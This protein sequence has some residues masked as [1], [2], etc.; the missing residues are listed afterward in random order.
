MA[1]ACPYNCKQGRLFNTVTR[2]FQSCPHCNDI[3]NDLSS[4]QPLSQ[5]SEDALARL[6]IPSELIGVK[7]DPDSFFDA[8]AREVFANVTFRTVLDELV[9]IEMAINSGRVLRGSRY[10]FTGLYAD[11]T[12]YVQHC[13]QEALRHGLSV[14]PYVS[15]V[16]LQGIRA[17]VTQVTRL[18][19]QVSYYDYTTAD[20]CFLAATAVSTHDEILLLSELLAERERHGLSTYVFGYWSE[21]ALKHGKN[22]LHFL[23]STE[24][25]PRLGLLKPYEVVT[26][27]RY[28]EQTGNK[29]SLNTLNNLGIVAPVGA[30][31]ATGQLVEAKKLGGIGSPQVGGSDDKGI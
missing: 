11:V 6:G 25:K 16:E 24:A 28:A 26:K 3:L 2:Q 21:V 19:N 27:A 13:L 10:F 17:D 9:G 29:G 4:S 18:Y 7:F 23:I 31:P 22:S 30:V 20:I 5:Q 14:V 1:Q 8:R 15:L 12:G